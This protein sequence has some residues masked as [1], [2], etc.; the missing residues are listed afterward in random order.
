MIDQLQPFAHLCITDIQHAPVKC[1]LCRGY[2]M[3]VKLGCSWCFEEVSTLQEEESGQ[4]PSPK[5]Y[6]YY[7]H[8]HLHAGVC[9][10]VDLIMLR[11]KGPPTKDPSKQWAYIP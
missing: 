3:H 5:T 2:Q 11:T 4:E 9:S 8:H 10:F 7:Y 6:Y 1:F